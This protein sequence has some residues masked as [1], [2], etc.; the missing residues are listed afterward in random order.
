MIG[1][2]FLLS[3]V[4]VAL[5][6][7]TSAAATCTMGKILPP[8]TCTGDCNFCDFV[9]M[10]VN[11]GNWFLGLGSLFALYFLV[12]GAFTMVISSGSPQRLE[13]GKKTLTGAIVGLVLVF[14]AWAV[15]N[16]AFMMFMG[17]SNKDISS[18]WWNLGAKCPTTPAAVPTTGE[19][20]P[21]PSGGGQC[22]NEQALAARYNELY[23]RADSSELIGLMNCIEREVPAGYIN[24]GN[25]WTY[26][27]HHF[28]CNYTRG[29]PICEPSDP[30][31]P[32]VT[33]SHSVNSCHYGGSNGSIGA[34]AVD[35]NAKSPYT[36]AQL[37]DKIDAVLDGPC[38]G[39]AGYHEFEHN[40]DHIHVSSIHC[41][42]N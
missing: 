23:P 26:D 37:W 22:A 14:A 10:F 36:D 24:F 30:A 1:G 17:E 12:N 19:Q 21:P 13:A 11:L 16:T 4:F 32:Q 33:C 34:E 41:N 20:T 3:F 18:S 5:P 7:P 35:Y 39:M 15:I 8:C 40:P 27:V 42:H 2:L 25:K 29:N 28:K 38:R 31:Y 9:L 6:M